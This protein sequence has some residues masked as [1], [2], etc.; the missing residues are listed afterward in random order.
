MIMPIC[1]IFKVFLGGLPWDVTELTLMKAFQPYGI[2]RI[3]WPGKE[4]QT[5]T[6]PKG[7]AYAV[8]ENEKQVQPS[9]YDNFASKSYNAWFNILLLVFDL[10]TGENAPAKLHCQLQQEYYW[11][12]LLQNIFHEIPGERRANYPL[13]TQWQQLHTMPIFQTWCTQDSVCGCSSWNGKRRG[14]CYDYEWFVWERC[15]C[16]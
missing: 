14:S 4:G 6:K 16:W 9:F 8:F 3:E 10:M 11:K 13:G 2:D 15:L 7:Y 5:T 1:C 12:L